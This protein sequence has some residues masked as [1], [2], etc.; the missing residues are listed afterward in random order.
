MNQY[1]VVLH[2]RVLISNDVS[3]MTLV[4]QYENLY[5]HTYLLFY[6]LWH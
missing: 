3:S 2:F 6:L 5:T 4:T 1:Y